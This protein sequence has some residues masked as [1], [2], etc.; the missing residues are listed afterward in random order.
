MVLSLNDL[1]TFKFHLL[2]LLIDRA[3]KFG[4]RSTERGMEGGVKERGEE[5]EERFRG[6]GCVER[7]GGMGMWRTETGLWT[8]ERKL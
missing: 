5:I 1:Q 2:R 3:V 8:I 6:G 7:S 4:L